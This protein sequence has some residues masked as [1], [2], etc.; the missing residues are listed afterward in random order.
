MD[1]W[2]L[3]R[4]I[5]ERLPNYYRNSNRTL[6]TVF[7]RIESGLERD[8]YMLLPLKKKLFKSCLENDEFSFEIQKS[9]FP[10][11][12]PAASQERDFSRRI[13]NRISD[14]PNVSHH[15]F[16]FYQPDT[17]D[18]IATTTNTFNNGRKKFELQLIKRL[19]LDDLERTGRKGV[20]CFESFRF[21]E[22]TL[23]D[24]GETEREEIIR[25]DSFV[26]KRIFRNNRNLRFRMNSF[27]V[28]HGKVLLG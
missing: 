25:E 28:I 13:Y 23:R 22:K 14:L 5:L 20:F 17:L 19:V 6:L 11:T 15:Q 4:D 8:F 7:G 18:D 9:D 21:S 2:L 26:Y 24:L 10:L 1:D 12:R 16:G 27:S 3:H